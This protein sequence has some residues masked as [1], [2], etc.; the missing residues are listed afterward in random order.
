MSHIHANIV[1][2]AA[3]KSAAF[4]ILLSLGLVVSVRAGLVPAS[5]PAA[6][7]RRAAEIAPAAERLLRFEDQPDGTVRVTD[8]RSG[9][10]AAVIGREGS[11]FIRGVLRGLARERRQH[12]HGAATPFR[13]TA[14][15]N[16]A[17]SIA[18]PATGRII[19][20]DGFG[21]TNRAAFARLLQER[22]A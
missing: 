5:T 8:V 4:L 16:G 17:L 9:A 13:L 14:W 11:G 22:G 7:L 21:P 18:D 3:L 15:A 12:G 20:L 19:E 2:P 1:P 10:V 6:E